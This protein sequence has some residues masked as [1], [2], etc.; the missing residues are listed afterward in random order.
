MASSL[1]ALLA[2]TAE[3]CETTDSET[4]AER[5]AGSTVTGTAAEKYSNSDPSDK[6]HEN[7][8][9]NRK[10]GSVHATTCILQMGE[11]QRSV[12]IRFLSRLKPLN[13]WLPTRKLAAYARQ[14]TLASRRSASN[15]SVPSP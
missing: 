4:A 12:R 8:Q 6:G 15:A 3:V 7:S 14:A 1:R 13:R 2:L 11:K 9:R 5:I 10:P